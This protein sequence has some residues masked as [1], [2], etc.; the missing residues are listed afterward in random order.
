VSHA[1]VFFWAEFPKQ[2]RRSRG[3][4]SLEVLRFGAMGPGKDAGNLL[5]VAAGAAAMPPLPV[6]LRTQRSQIYGGLFFG[7]RIIA[8]LFSCT[9]HGQG[10]TT[11]SV[12]VDNVAGPTLAV[13]TGQKCASSRIIPSFKSNFGVRELCLRN[14][15]QKRGVGSSGCRASELRTGVGPGRPAQR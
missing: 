11:E 1:L 7:P 5:P 2:L 9:E 3:R 8:L 12:R 13:I 6:S 4:R 10:A 15:S 14:S